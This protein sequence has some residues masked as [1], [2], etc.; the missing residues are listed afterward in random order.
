MDKSGLPISLIVYKEKMLNGKT[1]LEL[2]T[3]AYW[4]GAYIVELKSRSF[5]AAKRFDK[6]MM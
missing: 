1:S 3:A 2:S 6:I 5:T 4:P